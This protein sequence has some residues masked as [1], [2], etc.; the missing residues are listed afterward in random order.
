MSRFAATLTTFLLLAACGPKDDVATED[1][2]L[3]TETDEWGLITCSEANADE[4]C[5]TQRAVMGVSMGAGGAGML[6]LLRPDL[7]DSIGMLGV[8]IV[9]W[10]YMLRNID[11]SYLGGFCD[12]E[13]ILANLDA[14]DD[15]TGPAFC[16]PAEAVVQ[17]DREG[18]MFEPLQ[19]YNHW[20]RW[21]DEG[22]GGSFGRDK[23]R[24]SFQDIALAF[25]NPVAYNPDSPYFPPGV[26]MDF[27]TWTPQE[28]CETPMKL[29][30]VYHHEYNPDGTHDVLVF[31]DTRTNSGDFDPERP[32][33]VAMEIGLSVDYNGNGIRD[34]AEPVLKFMHERYEDVGRGP[35]DAYDWIDNPGG[36]AGNW[37]WDEGEP[38][39]DY[40]LDGV[41]GTGD[42]GEGNGKFDYNPNIE[43][44]LAQNP[45]TLIETIPEGHLDRMN[46]YADAG[47][48]DFLMSAA[49]TNW[50]WGSLQHRVGPEL[51][52]D[53]TAFKT[54]TPEL[55]KL[56]FLQVDYSEEGIGKHAYVR[57]GDPDASEREINRGDGH[58]VGTVSQVLNRFLVA[59][60]FAENRFLDRDVTDLDNVGE[61]R[62]LILPGTFFSEALQEERE[63]GVVLPPGYHLPD[64]ADRRYPVVYFMHGQ[65]MESD[66]LLA[67]AILFFGYQSSS[68]QEEKV[69]RRQSDWSK[70]II[71]FPDSTCSND[72]CEDGNFNTNH[73]GIDGNGPRYMDSLFEL[74][75]HV[76]GT[77]RTAI[78]SVVKRSALE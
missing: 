31:C 44:Y 6:G 56:D 29:E 73:P 16:G 10:V 41:D 37:K 9:D 63:F 77:Y 52:P 8:P 28:K 67:S 5:F 55:S 38:F 4:T 26:P 48:R 19:D 13:T 71:V 12:R 17:L 65:G 23:L 20:Y 39:L 3:R 78:P 66:Q 59:L 45:R 58:H 46:I 76:E 75:A 50:L 70:F 51:A 18:R 14:V 43:N 42:Y 11:R 30:G 34:F 47:I 21:I 24:K 36:Q 49:A 62:D 54:L 25:G 2:T 57:Y 1:R 27:R 22:R 74:M 64:N 32:S 72:A 7:F 60:A 15:P 53:Y 61:T 40:G 69:A 35:D 68:T 33:E